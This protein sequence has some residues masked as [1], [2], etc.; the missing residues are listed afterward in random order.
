MVKTELD[1]HMVLQ[2]GPRLYITLES[3]YYSFVAFCHQWCNRELFYLLKENFKSLLYNS[4]ITVR[5]FDKLS[6]LSRIPWYILGGIESD[7]AYKKVLVVYS[8]E[9]YGTH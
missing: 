2:Q 1:T 3:T 4:L 8:L 6:Y 9:A 7:L 5:Y